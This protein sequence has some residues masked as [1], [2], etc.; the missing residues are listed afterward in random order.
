MYGQE[1]PKVCPF[2]GS[3]KFSIRKVDENDTQPWLLAFVHC[4]GCSANVY[5][6]PD[7]D[8]AIAAWNRRRGCPS[9]NSTPR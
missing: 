9:S 7:T 2:C 6:Y 1:K 4:S 8:S 5:G 3:D